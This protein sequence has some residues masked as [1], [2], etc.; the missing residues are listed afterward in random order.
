MQ[1]ARAVRETA[2]DAENSAL[3]SQ[4]WSV[5]QASEILGITLN[6]TYAAIASGSIPIV[7]L[8]PRFIR[9]PKMA[10]ARLLE[11]IPALKSKG[12]A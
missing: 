3:A 6:A 7:R 12:V 1:G 9:V 4:T 8:R 5:R 11:G 2:K 10:L